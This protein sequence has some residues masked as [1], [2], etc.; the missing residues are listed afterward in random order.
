MIRNGQSFDEAHFEDIDMQSAMVADCVFSEC[1]FTNCNFSEA[2]FSSCRFIDCI[3][4]N[5]N[6]SLTEFVYCTMNLVEIRRS[7]CIGVNW[8]RIEATRF[9]RG[10]PFGFYDCTLSHATFLGM[11]LDE[12]EMRNCNATDAD[13]RN[14]SLISADFSNTDLKN[15][16][17]HSTNLTKATLSSARNYSI[18]PHENILTGAQFSLPEALS[19]LYALD[20]KLTET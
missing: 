2:T 9:A 19:L 18:T 12:L 13:F 20:I 16:L 11:A 8:S 4:D 7:K 15:A 3:F 17:F 5:C 1:K 6:L 14:C 10:A